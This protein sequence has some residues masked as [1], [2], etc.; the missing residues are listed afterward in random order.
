MMKEYFRVSLDKSGDYW[1]IIPE[2]EEVELKTNIDFTNKIDIKNLTI[3]KHHEKKHWEQVF[4]CLNLEAL[5]L[6]DPSDEQV[7]AIRKLTKL[8]RLRVIFLRTNDIKF[9]GDLLNLEEL[10]LEY[11]SGFSDLTPLLK[12]PKLKSIYF[13]N[14]RKVSNFQDLS[15]I[16]S[17]RY[18]R[19]SGTLETDQPI[20]N[21]E[22]LN[23]LL[24]LEVFSL[25]WIKNKTSF[26]AFLPMLHLKNLKKIEIGRDRFKTNEYAFLQ[27]AFPNIEGCSWDLF[28]EHNDNYEFLGKRAGFVKKNNP[29]AKVRCDE[30]V[31][32]FE[33]MK[34]ESAKLIKSYCG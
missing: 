34:K 17:L 13:E 7:Q 1:S 6:H 8:K 5:T 9:I 31:K 26:P 30:F 29:N 27:I 16:K 10:I 19:I 11:V 3:D 23:G 18:L 20:E 2:V 12:L 24:N 22:F 21:F 25:S 15:G 28:W 14:L 33:E 4:D 32:K